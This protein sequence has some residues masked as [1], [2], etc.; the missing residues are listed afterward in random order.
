MESGGRHP[1]LYFPDGD[2][3]LGAPFLH[4]IGGKS[5]KYQLYRVHKAYLAHHSVFFANLF[6]DGSAGLGP[7]YRHDGQPLVE[8]LDE[9][10]N[11]SRL[12]TYLYHP[13]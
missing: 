4:S 1:Q 11:F 9:A 2:V 5:E 6:A 12:L 13:L 3:V 7:T 10:E 8:V